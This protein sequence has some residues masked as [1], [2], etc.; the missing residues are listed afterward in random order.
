M[1]SDVWDLDVNPT[2]VSVGPVTSL[3]DVPHS[4]GRTG[5]WEVDVDEPRHLRLAYERATASLLQACRDQI[6]HAQIDPTGSAVTFA[7]HVVELLP[8]PP[9][10]SSPSS[11]S[12]GVGSFRV[13]YQTPVITFRPVDAF[14]RTTPRFH[15]L[16]TGQQHA[17]LDHLRSVRPLSE[18]ERQRR[19]SHLRDAEMFFRKG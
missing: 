9:K 2:R 4:S 8:Q 12:L 1:P 13:Y 7:F 16:S 19:Q 17:L 14:L 15:E 18:E 3:S 5:P 11:P 6:A 10:D